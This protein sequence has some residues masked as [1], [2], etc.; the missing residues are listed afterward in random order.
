[1][2]KRFVLVQSVKNIWKKISK[3]C[4][5]FTVFYWFINLKFLLKI[6]WINENLKKKPTDCMHGKTHLVRIDGRGGIRNYTEFENKMLEWS[7]G[8]LD[9]HFVKLISNL[10]RIRIFFIAIFNF[11][12]KFYKGKPIMIRLII[13]FLLHSIQY[14]PFPMELPVA[15]WL[16]CN[17]STISDIRQ[18][19][20][21]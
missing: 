9:L 13:I 12:I 4:Q 16:H 8:L 6:Q 7:E 5:I 15:V 19:V 21:S 18:I 2:T 3:K 20:L 17:G 10:T 14:D 11:S 1:M